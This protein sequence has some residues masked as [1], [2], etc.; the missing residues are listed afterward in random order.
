[1]RRLAQLLAVAVLLAPLMRAVGVSGVPE[2]IPLPQQITLGTGQFTLCEAQSAP[3]AASVR[4]LADAASRQ[5]AEYLATA[6]FRSTGRRFRID[7]TDGVAAA[8]GTILLTTNA[9]M[10]SLGGEGYEL[11]V[12]T[13]SV[14]V[15]APGQAGVFYGIQTILQL[16]PPEIYS[17][18]PGAGVSWTMPCLYIKDSPRFAWRGWMLDSVRH[19]FTVD[20]VKRFID[21]MA[22]HKLNVFHWHLDDDSGW[23]LEIKKWPLLTEVG[24]WR[25]D[26]MFGLNPR[27]SMAW[28]E[29]GMYGGF[30]TQAEAREIV[31]YA[32]QRHIMVVPEIEMPGH[33][34]SAL[35]AYPQ[36]ACGCASC[37]NGPY[38]LNVTSYV[39]GV[40]CIARPETLEFLKDVLTEVMDVFPGPY[41]HIGGDEVRFNNWQNHSLDQQRTNELGISS[42]QVYQGH[43]TQQIADWVKSQGRVMMGWSEIMN[44]GLV[45]NAALMDW[46]NGADSR[47]MQAATNRQPVVMCPSAT[48]Y[49][50]K[51]ETGTGSYGEGVIWSNEPPAQPG[52]VTLPAVYAFEPIPSGLP[53]AFTNYILGA[54]GNSW[55]EFIPSLQNMEFRIYPRLSAIAEV[56]W[57]QPSLKNWTG[58]TNRLTTHK[59]RLE[60]AGINFNPSQTPPQLGAWNS[61]MVSTT[62]QVV[63]W[64]VTTGITDAGEVDVSFCYK[65]G[66]NGL[67]IAWAALVENGVEVDRDTH[68][69]W[70]GYTPKAAV[71]VLRLRAYRPGAVYT[72][73]ASAAS[74]GGTHAN[75]IIYRTRWN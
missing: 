54:Q 38:S 19:F 23:R 5:N 46:K 55:T 26:M 9:S 67:D 34:S 7:S 48:L 62:Y 22:M 47:A 14:V 6:L 2:I 30:Y 18:R 52:L 44:G 61:S 69:G 41:I 1:M 17:P 8:P 32:A 57:T 15:R 12:D 56:S 29:D 73:R 45:T 53:P 50:N 24:G 72:L 63:E 37:Y 25:T 36:F 60:C 65:S 33:S 66:A 20:E 3:V 58:F 35:A 59:Q 51:Y 75:G 13:N 40:F 27:A 39:G 16:L 31:E 68:A 10:Q 70:T 71:Y 42:M 28:R 4:I 11:T 43:F 64:D 49:I 21:S 74:R